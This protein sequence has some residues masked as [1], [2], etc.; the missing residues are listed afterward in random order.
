LTL[1]L[2]HIYGGVLPCPW[3]DCAEGAAD[4]A[5]E[6]NGTRVWRQRFGEVFGEPTYAWII[7]GVT[8]AY[9]AAQFTRR[10]MA[11]VNGAHSVA[12][13]GFMYHFTDETGLRGI[14]AS[15]E[16]WLTD[17][18]D[19][20]DEQEIRDGQQV[21]KATFDALRPDLQRETNSLLDTLLAAP[22]PSGVYVSCF[23]VMRAS[24]YH[25]SEFAA[26]S[27]GAVLEMDPLGFEQ[28]LA[29]DPF[30]IQ[31]TRVAYIWDVKAG[32]FAH[33]ATW[34]EELVSFDLARGLFARDIY[35]REMTQIFGELL[36]MCKD[37]SLFR[38]RE[39][40]VIVTPAQSKTDLASKLAV[41]QTNE[42][43]YIT[44]RDVL[45][46]FAL[47][48]KSVLLGPKFTGD[49]SKLAI[50]GLKVPKFVA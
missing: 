35:L 37:V 10:A 20:R 31:F 1:C 8:A 48:I 4:A 15:G 2:T 43:R 46:S 47:P 27:S 33:L 12:D 40:R 44:T 17:Y 50:D 42:R 49:I 14:L 28:L 36:P 21:A 41:R 30:A 6:F 5:F 13:D 9:V 19:L 7:D 24:S 34:L 29:C 25:W 32:L 45:P 23:C 11:Q 18:R 22:L 39:I 3:P 38:E 16:L 26:D